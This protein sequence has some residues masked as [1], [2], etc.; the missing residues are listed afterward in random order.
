MTASDD[1]PDESEVVETAAT[2]AEETVF[3]H[4]SRS[5]VRDLDV[6]VTFENEILEVDVYLD[7][8][9]DA[10]DVEQV[11]EAAARA[12]RSAVDELLE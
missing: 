6:T 8:P 10:V 4:Y 9:D 3:S 2:A 12:A 11:A 7:A 5:A 1:R